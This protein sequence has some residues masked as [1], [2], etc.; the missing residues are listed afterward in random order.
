MTGVKKQRNRVSEKKPLKAVTA[1]F[2]GPTLHHVMMLILAPFVIGS[3]FVVAF[4]VDVIQRILYLGMP[5]NV[6]DEITP[7]IA[8]LVGG[9]AWLLVGYIGYK[10]MIRIKQAAS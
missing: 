2:S 1:V 3:C 9:I 6:V 4:V 7:F 5:K 8:C 10:I